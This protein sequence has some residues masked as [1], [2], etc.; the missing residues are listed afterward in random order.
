MSV[1]PTNTEGDLR[2]RRSERRKE[3]RPGWLIDLM[4]KARVPL[5]TAAE[6]ILTVCKSPRLNGSAHN[7]PGAG[8][9]AAFPQPN[10]VLTRQMK[11]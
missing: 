11:T 6:D 8:F 3:L 9:D 4:R 5:D 7:V 2:D 10:H 1:W